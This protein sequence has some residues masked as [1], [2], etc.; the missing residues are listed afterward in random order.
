MI[1]SDTTVPRLEELS[2]V[3]SDLPPQR[4]HCNPL[5]FEM[6]YKDGCHIDT[7][8][9]TAPCNID[10]MGKLWFSNHLRWVVFVVFF[11]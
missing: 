2:N 7:N 4:R 1:R 5:M 8:H 9:F 6:A 11:F 3:Y 10:P